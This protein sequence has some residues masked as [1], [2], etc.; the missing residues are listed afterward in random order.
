MGGRCHPF[1]HDCRECVRI[2]ATEERTVSH[3]TLK[4]IRPGTNRQCAAMNSAVMS[5]AHLSTTL[6]GIEF[7]LQSFVRCGHLLVT[8]FPCPRSP[9]ALALITG[10][11][12]VNPQDRL[13][14]ADACQH[15]WV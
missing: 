2:S 15:P 14:L 5:R 11:L 1:Y 3:P 9:L 13:S 6:R 12:A 8:R 10:L 7:P 4:K